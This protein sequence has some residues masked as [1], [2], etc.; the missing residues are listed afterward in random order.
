[1]A[2]CWLAASTVVAVSVPALLLALSQV[3][4]SAFQVAE[5]SPWASISLSG[6]PAGTACWTVVRLSCTC[7]LGASRFRVAS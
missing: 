2:G 7:C 6:M 4:V 3:P 1:M 5:F